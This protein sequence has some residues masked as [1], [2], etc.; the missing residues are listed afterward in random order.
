MN[1]REAT[2]DDAGAMCNILNYYIENSLISHETV[3]VSE[4]ESKK[5]ISDISNSGHLLYIGE[6][7]GKIIGFCCTQPWNSYAV[8]ETTAEE[9]IFL[10]KDETGKGYGTQLLEHMLNHIG[11]TKIHILNATIALPNEGSVRLH[12]KFGFK[13]VSHMK[14]IGRK[15]DQWLDIG[16]WQLIL[17]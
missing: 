6:I 8:Y 10:D 3:P 13:Q 9:S 12:E 7:N 17:T 15:F 5:R 2:L 16:C 1:I 14:E 4:I 11:K